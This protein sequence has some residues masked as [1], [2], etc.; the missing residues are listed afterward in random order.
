VGVGA[1]CCVSRAMMFLQS[2]D[3]GLAHGLNE[4]YGAGKSFRIN[5]LPQYR[6]EVTSCGPRPQ[7]I[8]RKLR[9]L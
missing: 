1:P 5:I 6:V 8:L 3:S 7:R 2:C 9:G 4:S